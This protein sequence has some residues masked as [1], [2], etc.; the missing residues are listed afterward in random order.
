MESIEKSVIAPTALVVFAGEDLWSSL[1]SIAYFQE[2]ERLDGVF[3]YQTADR[4]SALP[5]ER[6]RRFC[7]RR[8]PTLRVV[9]PGEPGAASAA[10]VA[11]RVGDWRRFRPDV[12]RWVLDVTGVSRAMLGGVSMVLAA[13]KGFEAIYRET[14]GVW[15]ALRWVCNGQLAASPLAPPI[16]AD[17][18]DTLPVTEL[19]ELL[20]TDVA[21][22]RFRESRSPEPLTP[23]Q[24]GRLVT[25]GGKCN[26]DWARMYA[27]VMDRPGRLEEFAF[28]DFVAATL[29]SMG[30][31]NV[32]VNLKVV[33]TGAKHLET[34]LDLIVNRR[35]RLYVFDCRARDEQ[36]D[37]GPPAPLVALD[38]LW[39]TC[40]VL[41]PNRWATDAE[42]MLAAMGSRVH[43]I[44]ADGC[45]HLFSWLAGLMDVQ[46]PTVLRDLERAA[47]R[48]GVNRLPVFTPATQA[49]RLGDAV[50]LGDQ[51][52]D[53]VKG[54]RVEDDG[55][56]TVWRAARVTP[57]L[58]FIEGRVLQGGVGTEMQRRLA[59]RFAEQKLPATIIFFELLPNKKFWHAL[60]RI[61]GEM[62]VFAKA[63]HKWRNIP[64]IV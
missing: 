2:H 31:R 28:E 53:L 24:I 58:W 15:Q 43:V 42:R 56:E 10:K 18:T 38:G 35:G 5:A 22:I 3:I 1:Q 51:V 46:P 44:D 7:S 14:D 27:V 19:V 25:T 23:E 39:P 57:D 16:P 17:V 48:L 32:R 33:Q 40:V 6:L 61:P 4:H 62:S 37:P 64:L 21:E 26:W 52:F 12:K 34:S 8:W 29:L 41:R 9:L 59:V 54:G 13:D 30:V 47:L 11:E 49:Q 50:R 60:V 55:Q 20:A 36:R 63:L 45:R